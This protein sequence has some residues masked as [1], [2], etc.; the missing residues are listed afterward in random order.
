[1]RDVIVDLFN[2]MLDEDHDLVVREFMQPV[3]IP[4][5]SPLYNHKVAG[6]YKGRKYMSRLD[7]ISL[8][9]S[10]MPIVQECENGI[11]QRFR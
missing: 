8:S 4:I 2:K 11:V 7:F 6:S 9:C 3:D 5:G 10:D 1:M